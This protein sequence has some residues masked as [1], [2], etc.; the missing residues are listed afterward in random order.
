MGRACPM[1]EAASRKPQLPH[2]DLQADP[3]LRNHQ[4]RP[5]QAPSTFNPGP[6]QGPQL[7]KGPGLPPCPAPVFLH[8]GACPADAAAPEGHAGSGCAGEAEVKESQT[9]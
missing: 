6:S 8:R 9:F 3:V 4:P 7:P 2:P 5:S 1:G